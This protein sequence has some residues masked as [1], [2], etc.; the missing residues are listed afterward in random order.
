[1]RASLDADEGGA[2][3]TVVH[4]RLELV[5]FDRCEAASIP[6]RFPPDHPV[7]DTVWQLLGV[8]GYQM[9]R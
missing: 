1:M 4:L 7:L 8:V 9:W 3:Y 6:A 2:E 5:A